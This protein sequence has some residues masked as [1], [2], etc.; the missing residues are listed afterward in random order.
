MGEN[1][2][3]S[4]NEIDNLL[5]INTDASVDKP[6]ASTPPPTMDQ[7]PRKADSGPAH[8]MDYKPLHESKADTTVSEISMI[9]DIPLELS[10]EL[11]RAKK[12]I[13]EIL[14]F[15]LG[16]VVELNKLAGEPV[17]LLA[18]K[19]LIA[20][21]EVVVIEDNFAIRITEIINPQA[22]TN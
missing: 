6:V 21:G 7:K 15:G 10:V 9:R 5:G 8:S 3:I 16:T 14:E 1:L 18:N 20:R 13:K 11:G 2:S 22:P 19:K 12:T 4:Q 17:D